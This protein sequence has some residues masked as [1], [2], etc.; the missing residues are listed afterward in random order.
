MWLAI[1]L[2]ALTVVEI[3]FVKDFDKNNQKRSV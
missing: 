2:V 1:S 3:L